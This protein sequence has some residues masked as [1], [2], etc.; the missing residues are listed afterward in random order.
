MT[1]AAPSPSARTPGSGGRPSKE[2]F[3]HR[4]FDLIT[5]RYDLFN[6][7]ASLGLDQPW[8]RRTLESLGLLPEMRVLDLACGT[9]DL[10]A[11]AARA[12]VPLGLVVGCDLSLPMMAAGASKLARRPPARWH[13]KF[14]QGRAEQLPFAAGFHAA[15][16][17]FAL[18][19]VSDLDAVFRELHRVLRPGGR[20]G[21]LEFGR[22][23]SPLLR[24]G[25]I[26]WLSFAI[27]VIG[28]LTTGRLWPFLYLRRSILG[29]L[30]S[31]EVVRR[32]E[33][34]GFTDAEAV[35]MTG[36]AV[37]LYTALR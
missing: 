21:L 19:N 26:A 9:G 8:R 22:P 24:L 35:P 34:A 10:A 16:M 11:A 14:A 25:H 30:P 3:V 5:P 2:A 32:L 36:G 20:I 6:R 23:R 13:V 31:E 33:A 7:I 17:G 4:L 37:V 27:P 18:R 29:F 28:L 12:L 1:R 15:V